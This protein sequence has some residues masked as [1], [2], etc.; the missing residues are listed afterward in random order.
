MEVHCSSYYF[1]IIKVIHKI[2]I[3]QNIQI[4]EKQQQQANT[5]RVLDQS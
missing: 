5:D 1:F 3:K 4:H 2:Q